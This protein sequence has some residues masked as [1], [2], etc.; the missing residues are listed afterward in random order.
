[1]HS[2]FT[3]RKRSVFFFLL[4]LVAAGCTRISSTDLGAGLIPPIDGVITKDT[5]LDVITDNFDDPDTARVYRSDIHM[6]GAITNDPL[7]GK[8]KASMFFEMQPDVYPFYIPGTKD[9]IRVDSAV[10][11]LN[12]AGVYGDSTQPLRINVAEIDPATPINLT[13]NYPVNYPNVFPINTIGALAN[14]ITVD[15]R[16]LGDSVKNRFEQT[17]NQLRIRLRNDVAN[18]FIKLYDSSNTYKSDSLLRTVFAGFALTVDASSPANALLRINVVDTSSKLALYYNSSTTGATKRDTSVRYF[19]CHSSSSGNVN[20]I[21][22]DRTGSQAAQHFTTTA[23]PDSLVYVQTSPGTY[24]R[25]RIPGLKD[26]SNRIIHRAELITEQVPDDANSMLETQMLPPRFLLLSVFDSAN[27]YKRNIPNDFVLG[28]SG[29]NI[30]TFGGNLIYKSVPG[31]D[32]LATYVFDMSRYVQGIVTRK[33]TVQTLR[34][35]APTN[36]SLHYTHPY[37][38]NAGT[39]LYY[40]SPALGN[41]IGQGRVRLGGGTHSRFRMRLRVIYSRI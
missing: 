30:A 32:R 26:L 7:F 5:L 22:R 37:P 20:F 17:A 28:S 34:L 10:L 41:T 35:T 15:I 40:I 2:F 12:Y 33:D 9:S 13:R 39:S 23:K 24:V 3:L 16:R 1:M 31:Y 36:D 27:N 21:T 38:A 19:R 29:P 14:P 25:L 11:I 8:T 18:R 6:L 4:L